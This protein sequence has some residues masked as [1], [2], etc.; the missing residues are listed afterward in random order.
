MF[1]GLV[2][3]ESIP[4]IIAQPSSSGLSPKRDGKDS[5]RYLHSEAIKCCISIY[6]L[7]Q[8]FLTHLTPQSLVQRPAPHL[9]LMVFTF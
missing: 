5:F 1:K 6:C 2:A 4:P 8:V 7:T 3:S 9:K